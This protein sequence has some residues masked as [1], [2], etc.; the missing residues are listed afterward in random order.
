MGGGAVLVLLPSPISLQRVCTTPYPLLR[1]G[2][3]EWVG[4]MGWGYFY[5]FYFYFYYFLI[6]FNFFCYGGLDKW[7]VYGPSLNKWEAV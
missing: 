3:G 2:I 7:E 4:E 6:F 5:Y 1:R